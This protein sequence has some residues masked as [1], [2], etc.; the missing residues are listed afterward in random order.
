MLNRITRNLILLSIALLMALIY[1]TPYTA[2]GAQNGTPAATMATC[3]TE[4]TGPA[5]DVNVRQQVILD[6]MRG[7]LLVSLSLWEKGNYDLAQ[8]HSNQPIQE[9]L[10]VIRGDLK[11]ICLADQLTTMLASYSTFTTKAGGKPTVEKAYQDILTTLDQSS[12]KLIPAT[13][14]KDA[15]FNFRVIAGMLDAAQTEYTEAIANGKVVKVPEYQNGMGFTLVALARYQG[16]QAVVKEKYADLD[17]TLTSYWKTL[18]DAYQDVNPPDKPVD[19]VS[20]SK[21]AAGIKAAASK[22]LN[23]ALETPLTPLEYLSNARSG[24]NDAIDLYA[25]G[26]ADAAYETAASAYLDQY[27]HTETLLATKD[28]N[29]M[30]AIEAQ[31]KDIRDAIKANKPLDEVKALLKPV[32]DNLDKASALLSQ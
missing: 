21:A 7:H 15:T 32:L 14:Q 19:P 4:A 3:V 8:A 24:L 6:K 29:L 18:R 31:M 20:L 1:I 26:N 22:A 11:R 16:I 28:K 5:M 10:S 13:S 23:V 27:E 9:L 12:S 30:S 17:T 25:N 2:L